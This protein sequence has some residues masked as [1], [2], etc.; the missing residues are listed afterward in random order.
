M[1]SKDLKIY[2]DVRAHL[3]WQQKRKVSFPK[4]YKY[5]FANDMFQSLVRCLTLIRRAN[6]NKQRRVQYLAELLEELD[7]YM[8]YIGLCDDLRLLSKE[9]EMPKL[10]LD[11]TTIARQA[12]GWY[13]ASVKAA[14]SYGG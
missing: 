3:L 6:S 4:D 9:K 7:V 8:M 2:K 10:I 13:N 14:N 12:Q 5:A 1:L 11:L